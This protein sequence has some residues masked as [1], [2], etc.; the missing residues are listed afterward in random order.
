M[1]LKQRF[2]LFFSLL[3]S[4]LLAA[5]MMTV[6]YLFANFRQEEFI[7]RLSEKAETTIRLLVEVDEVDYQTLKIIDRN[8]INRLYNE[9][10]LIFNDS[11]QLIYSSLD[12][13]HLEW[14][15]E[16]LQ[17]IKKEKSL[18]RKLGQIDVLGLY[19]DLKN[20]D[21]FVL[22][23]A[24]DKYGNRKLHYLKYLLTGAF[25][26]GTALVWILSF[27]LSKQSLY[28]LDRVR[29]RIQEI[30]GQN[31]NTRL[32]T[33]GREDEINALSQSFNQMM[34][35]ID[36]AYQRQKEFTGNASHELRTPI[37]R[38]VTQLENILNRKKLSPA[39]TMTIQ[40]I[41]EDAYE[42]SDMVTSLLLLSSMA[43]KEE[44][45][46][47][48]KVRLDEL[49]FSAA[50]E[51]ARLHPG[52]RLRFEI[53]NRSFD[54]TNIEVEGDET[55]LKI[56]LLNLLKNACSYSEDQVVSCLVCQNT[57]TL[58]VFVTNRGPVPDAPDLAS[59]FN[60][61]TR[62]SNV[63][64]KPG[65]GVGLSIVQRVLQYH[66]ARVEYRLPDEQT[67]QIVITFPRKLKD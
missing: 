1:N 11:M 57:P 45:A 55:L 8:T 54:E 14:S 10:T 36:Q 44:A 66:L 43:D 64:N 42:L 33:T 6:Y 25:L 5:V 17:Q 40:S 41:A 59:L 27:Y 18:V 47:F 67:N 49:I 65:S 2:S 16:E 63:L 52:F 37:A 19:F 53:E 35:R 39:E 7:D 20:Q 34:D 62:G 60:T 38:M 30:T 22:V 26:I 13:P 48:R 31:L 50:S 12:D 51:I 29:S 9:K 23:S 21:Y 24:E 4:V 56:A 15:P 3:F 46:A 28:P 61:F 32:P 58:Q